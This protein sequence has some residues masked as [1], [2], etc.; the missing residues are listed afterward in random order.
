M[1]Q[2]AYDWI[3][4]YSTTGKWYSYNYQIMTLA[5]RLSRIMCSRRQKQSPNDWPNNSFRQN[6]SS[7]DLFFTVT[8][9]WHSDTAAILVQTVPFLSAL[10][11]L[12]MLSRPERIH[13]RKSML[14]KTW[15]SPIHS[16]YLFF[17]KI[18]LP[19]FLIYTRSRLIKEIFQYTLRV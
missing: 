13:G 18:N 11:S 10:P 4:F 1:N 7:S 12:C 2:K 6:K 16:F 3:T 8:Q 19:W 17:V 14:M 9:I 5:S 15:S